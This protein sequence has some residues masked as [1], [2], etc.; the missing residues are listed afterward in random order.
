[1]VSA[2][3]QVPASTAAVAAAAGAAVSAVVPAAADDADIYGP[4]P[5]TDTAQLDGEDDAD[6]PPPLPSKTTPSTGKGFGKWTD[7]R[8][9]PVKTI[10]GMA[11]KAGKSKDGKAAESSTDNGPLAPQESDGMYGSMSDDVPVP[12]QSSD[13]LYAAVE[14]TP[15]LGNGLTSYDADAYKEEPV[16]RGESGDSNDDIYEVMSRSAS[17][18]ANASAAPPVPTRSPYQ[19]MVPDSDTATLSVSPSAG[20]SALPEEPDPGTE[21]Y[22]MPVGGEGDAAPG[23]APTSIY[24]VGVPPPARNKQEGANGAKDEKALSVKRN[25]KPASMKKVRS[26]SIRSQNGARW[27]V[28]DRCVAVYEGD[29]MCYEGT[30][31]CVEYIR[32]QCH[33]VFDGYDDHEVVPLTEIYTPGEFAEF[34]SEFEATEAGEGGEAHGGM[35]GTENEEGLNL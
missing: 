29:G 27:K 17:E 24:N 8:A 19:V 26:G 14:A 2:A 34:E 5:T 11:G 1:M 15:Y 30:I 4:E 3:T 25:R 18:T 23:T 7:N 13:G 9:M 20:G 21:M 16:G 22:E 12:S 33:V 6:A 32:K 28:N 35:E 10:A 31:I